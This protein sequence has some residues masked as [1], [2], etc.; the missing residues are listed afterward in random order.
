MLDKTGQVLDPFEQA[1]AEPDEAALDSVDNADASDENLVLDL[2][3]PEELVADPSDDAGLQAQF[4]DYLARN[5]PIDFHNDH[6]ALK[7]ILPE[8]PTLPTAQDATHPHSQ[9]K[10]GKLWQIA[11]PVLKDAAIGG[12]VCSAGG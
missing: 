3:D 1:Q 8:S 9:S 4:G 6:H 10:I 2:P 12:M 7:A 5:P 11:G